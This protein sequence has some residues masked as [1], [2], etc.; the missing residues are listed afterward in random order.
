MYT[1]IKT[2]R[3][4]IKPYED[5]DRAAMTELLT[6][7]QIKENYMI[8]DFRDEDEAAAMFR[9]LKELSYSDEHFERG[10]YL[11][12]RL[13]GFVNDVEIDGDT[14]ELGYGIHPNRKNRG[15]ASEMLKAV[16]E[17]LFQKGFRK[18]LACVFEQN[19]ASIR[20]M[21]KSGMVKLEKETDLCYHGERRRCHYYA[22]FRNGG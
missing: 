9:K 15:Y 22:A 14:I 10:I 19:A 17:A 5:T 13:I 7:P 20:V 2:E 16:I 21:Q 1:T 12:G 18:V 4:E 6:D 3:L 8:P 11:E